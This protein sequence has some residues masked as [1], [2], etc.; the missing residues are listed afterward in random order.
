MDT[1]LEQLEKAARDLAAATKEREDLSAR[2]ERLADRL[3]RGRFNV[4]VLGEFKRGKSTLVN[5]LLGL[6]LM[7]TGVLPLTAVATEVV[8]GTPGG[9]VVHTDGSTEE[10]DLSRLS[11]YVTEAGNPAQRTP[12]QAGGGRRPARSSPPRDRAGGHARDRL[13]FP[14]R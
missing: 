8:Y 14:S 4:S 2:A 3:A 12:G 10:I 13:G 9:T 11:D 1:E 7:P 6:D 5:A